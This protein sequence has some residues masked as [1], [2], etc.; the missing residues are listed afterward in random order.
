MPNLKIRWAWAWQVLVMVLVLATGVQAQDTGSLEGQVLNGTAGGPDI[1]AGVPVTLRVFRGETELEAVETTTSGDGRFRFDGLD[2][3]ADLQY[4]PEAVYDGVS[5]PVAEALQFESDQTA[6][7]VTLTVYE[8]TD[9]DGAI[10]L[11]S[12]HLIAESFGEVL[13]ISEI[14][15]FGNSGDRT[16]IGRTGDGDKAATVHILLPESAVGIAFE[17]DASAERFVEVEDGVVD[18]EPVPPGTETSL[19][20]FS[21]HLMAAG[22]TV[23]LERRFAYPVSN[24]NMLVAQP[25]LTLRSDQLIS[26]GQAP[27]QDREYQFYETVDLAPDT[28]L[29]MEFIVVPDAS[30]GEGAATISGSPDAAVGGT[31]VKGSQGMLRWLGLALALLALFGVIA[32]AVTTK[33]RPVT[34]A[35]APPLTTDPQSRRLLAD[36]ADLE[37]AR[38]AGEIDEAAY[39]RRRGEIYE[40]LKAS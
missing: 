15:I 5:Y 25:G 11:D 6:L 7:D 29:R 27:F 31:L 28:P 1:G 4:W 3:A 38:E 36:L 16:Y 2:T 26:G 37:D 18:T 13:R 10:T 35:Q 22:D 24:L 20:F 14:H 30:M 23:P 32:L 21:Y 39:E 40:V 12:V 34:T 19:V 8:T 33:G 17:Q 9:D